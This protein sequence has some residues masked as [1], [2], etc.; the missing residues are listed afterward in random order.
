MRDIAFQ[1]LENFPNWNFTWFYVKLYAYALVILSGLFSA[2]TPSSILVRNFISF[3]VPWRQLIIVG[4]KLNTYLWTFEQTKEKNDWLFCSL[5]EDFSFNVRILAP[6]PLPLFS[7]KCVSKQNCKWDDIFVGHKV[8][9]WTR[10]LDKNQ[11]FSLHIP[12]TGWPTNDEMWFLPRFVI[13]FFYSEFLIIF[14]FPER[15]WLIN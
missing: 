3:I 4:T 15:N 11:T 13:D 6:S 7:H 5:V 10:I 8:F 9:Y 1:E 14:F 2:L 12:P